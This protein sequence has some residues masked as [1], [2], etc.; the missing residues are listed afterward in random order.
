M[1]EPKA[2][3]LYRLVHAVAQR[4]CLLWLFIVLLIRRRRGAWCRVRVRWSTWPMR[5]WSLARRGDGCCPQSSCRV[6]DDPGIIQCK[7]RATLRK[8][9]AIWTVSESAWSI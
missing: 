7:A 2:S 9:L 6:D 3:T 4:R 5:C 1:I 8:R